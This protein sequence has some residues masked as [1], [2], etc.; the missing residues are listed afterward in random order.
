[1]ACSRCG[2]F[3]VVDEFMDAK[4]EYSRMWFQGL[5]CI[6][7]GAIDEGLIRA[8][9]QGL[10]TPRHIGPLAA[11]RFPRRP[12]ALKSEGDSLGEEIDTP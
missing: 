6:N 1:M 9:R 2:G 12:Q 7:C 11:L 4:E 10:A 8:N 3:L 5:R